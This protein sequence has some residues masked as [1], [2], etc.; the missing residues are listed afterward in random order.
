MINMVRIHF[1]LCHYCK[2]I[3]FL[4]ANDLIMIFDPKKWLFS[5]IGRC[6]DSSVDKLG[7]KSSL[8]EVKP[9]PGLNQKIIREFVVKLWKKGDVGFLLFVV[10]VV[11]VNF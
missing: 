5:L 11:I 9:D 2:I 3:T 4:I 10:I 6:E 8:F 7:L 1:I